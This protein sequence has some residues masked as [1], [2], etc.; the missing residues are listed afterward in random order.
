[1]NPDDL[2]DRL[3]AIR[4]P[5][6]FARFGVQD[7]LA[8]VA[9]GLLAGVLIATLLQRLTIRRAR[10]LDEA[11]SA[12]AALSGQ[13]RQVRITGLAALLRT[14]GGMPIEGLEAAL[15]DPEATV[16]SDDLEAAVLAAA[17][18]RKRP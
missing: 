5:E 4:I 3:A 11:R 18:R 12:I 14:H 17:R 7:A 1:M 13:E 2:V 6:A 16:S 9:L 10:P 15:Y 8:A